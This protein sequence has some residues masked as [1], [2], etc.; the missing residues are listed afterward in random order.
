[1]SRSGIKGSEIKFDTEGI[2]FGLV[3]LHSE[4]AS[5]NVICENV[6]ER[7]RNTFKI[8]NWGV[9]V[10]STNNNYDFMLKGKRYVLY[11]Q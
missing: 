1:M 4:H 10:I 7:A 3:F 2:F 11:T 6:L 8:P 5:A 9:R